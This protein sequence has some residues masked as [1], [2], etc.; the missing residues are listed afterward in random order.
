MFR[1]AQGVLPSP[2]PC[3]PP[4]QPVA[5]AH[6]GQDTGPFYVR[7]SSE[8]VTSSRKSAQPRGRRVAALPHRDR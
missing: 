5:D 1:S 8:R 7:F 4:Q 2:P 3:L 6:A